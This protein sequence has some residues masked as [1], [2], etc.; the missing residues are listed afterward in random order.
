MPLSYLYSTDSPLCANFSYSS[1]T[2]PASAAD[3]STVFTPFH[4][5]FASDTNTDGIDT[6]FMKLALQQVAAAA[7]QGEFPIGAVVVRKFINDSSQLKL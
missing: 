7:V 5:R 1:Y 2:T 3:T 4:V 6:H